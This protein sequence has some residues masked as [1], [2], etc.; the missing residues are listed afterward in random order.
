MLG[1][2]SRKLAVALL[3]AH[4]PSKNP[5]PVSQMQAYIV[6]L[7]SSDVL[8]PSP[9]RS[10]LKFAYSPRNHSETRS[11]CLVSLATFCRLL[12]KAARSERFRRQPLPEGYMVRARMRPLS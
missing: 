8:R 6:Y 3:G 9:L 4:T 7:L 10:S 12:F 1:G 11:G 5:L 2:G